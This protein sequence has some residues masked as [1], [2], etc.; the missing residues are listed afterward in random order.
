MIGHE[1]SKSWK[2]ES[3]LCMGSAALNRALGLL[4]LWLGSCGDAPAQ[5]TLRPLHG[6]NGACGRA[7]DAR[8][9]LVSSLSSDRDVTRSFSVDGSAAALTIADFPIGTEQLSVSVVGAGGAVRSVGKTAP[10][11]FSALVDG[12][13]IPV[14]LAPTNAGCVIAPM[15]NPR[16]NALLAAAGDGAVVVAGQGVSGP[17]VNAEYFDATTGSFA[18]VALP[19]AFS[20]LLSLEGSALTSLSDGRAVLFAA[21]VGAYSIFDPAT[22]EFSKPRVFEPRWHFATVAIDSHRVAV[23]GGCVSTN[24]SVCVGN[25]AA[26]VLVV[27]VTADE[28][29]VLGNLS[30]Q[31]IDPDVVVEPTGFSR[32]RSLLIVGGTTL[33]GLASK[34]VERMDLATGAVTEVT[35]SGRSMMLDSGATL[36]GFASAGAAATDTLSVVVPSTATVRS[37]TAISSRTGPQLVLQQDGAVLVVGGGGPML[38]YDPATLVTRALPMISNGDPEPSQQGQSA[39]RLSDGS[40]LVVGGESA[41][42]AISTAWRYRPA[43]MGPTSSSALVSPGISDTALTAVD[44]S[45]LTATAAGFVL[46]S[47]SEDISQ[48]AVVG[49]PRRFNGVARALLSF[50]NANDGVAL[51]MHYEGPAQ[52]LAFT[53]RAGRPVELVR[54][55]VTGLVAICSGTVVGREQLTSTQVEVAIQGR[56]ATATVQ[57]VQVLK[58]TLTVDEAARRGNVAVAA[59]GVAAS[60]TLVQLSVGPS[61]DR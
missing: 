59:F 47:Q 8:L 34:Q 61:S 3:E 56:S 19:T 32:G 23:V 37:A 52:W 22:R 26:R 49:G 42:V 51:A 58:C 45:S 55:D 41:G 2:I 48:F 27:D 29:S 4:L 7:A 28:V 9:L 40:V 14:F 6:S 10:L 25:A 15:V 43:L 50:A 17:Q 44:P 39:T 57:G 20:G 33:A 12:T 35:A 13:D 16:R 54:R 24:Q 60:A 31:H 36:T 1:H 46:T 53:F 5:V 11:K 18:A 30:A 38:S 21:G